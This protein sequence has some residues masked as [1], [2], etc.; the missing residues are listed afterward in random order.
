MALD[1]LQEGLLPHCAHWLT[2][3]QHVGKVLIRCYSS[4]QASEGLEC[5]QDC[6]RTFL[7]STQLMGWSSAYVRAVRD[8]ARAAGVDSKS[9]TH[10]IE[11]DFAWKVW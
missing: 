6:R 5:T 9:P 2:D 1:A 10:L 3:G 7:P 4:G 8:Q 11:E